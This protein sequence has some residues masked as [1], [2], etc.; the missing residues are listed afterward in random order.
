MQ[1][2]NNEILLDIGEVIEKVCQGIFSL[3]FIISI[4]NH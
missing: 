2:F 4:I 1:G 3:N